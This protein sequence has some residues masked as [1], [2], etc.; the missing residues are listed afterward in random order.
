[1]LCMLP[2]MPEPLNV[3]A[4]R[5]R[6]GVVHRLRPDDT[7][8]LAAARSDLAEAKIARLIAEEGVQLT[9]AARKRLGSL[10]RG[11]A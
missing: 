7:A 10:L 8:A 1:M 6:L 5:N 4:A 2:T 9:A 3:V 11:A